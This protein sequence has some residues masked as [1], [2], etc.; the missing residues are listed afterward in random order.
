MAYRTPSV[1]SVFPL[2]ATTLALG[3]LALGT[4]AATALAQAPDASLLRSFDW[5]ARNASAKLLVENPATQASDLLEVLRAE[6]H[7]GIA[8]VNRWNSAVGLGGES[9]EPRQATLRSARDQIWRLYELSKPRQLTSA[10]QL[11]VPWHPHQLA[12]WILRQRYTKSDLPDLV[13]TSNELARIWLTCHRPDQDALRLALAD[14][15]TAPAVATAMWELDQGFPSSLLEYLASGSIAARRAVLRLPLPEAQLQPRHIRAVID[16]F[17][18][19]DDKQH[20]GHAGAVL[21]RLGE[22]AAVELIPH[23]SKGAEGQSKAAAVL[24]LMGSAAA[25]ATSALLECLHGDRNC[26]RRALVALSDIHMDPELRA[27]VAAKVFEVLTSTKTR[28]V[29]TVALDALA[30]CGDGVTAELK[31][32]LLAMFAKQPYRS[33]RTRMLGCMRRLQCLPK[34]TTAELVRIAGGSY[35]NTDTWMAVADRGQEAADA[36]AKCI[37]V[38]HPGVD[39][40]KVAAVLAQTAPQVLVQWLSSEERSLRLRA[41]QTLRAERLDLLDSN[42]LLSMLADQSVAGEAFD[43]LCSLP[44]ANALLPKILAATAPP[45]IYMGADRGP[46]LRKLG[47]DLPMLLKAFDAHLRRGDY[48][49]TVRGLDDDTLKKHARQWIE[50]SE[51]PKV[52]DQLRGEFVRL[53]LSQAVDLQMFAQALRSKHRAHTLAVM[54]WQKDLP[55]ELIPALEAICSDP[56]DREEFENA[57]KAL[58]IATR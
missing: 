55:R 6:W 46:V 8:E 34:L 48:W 20:A 24:C 9:R 28:L 12:E 27:T 41:L 14:E 25:P 2:S 21:V 54:S 16:Q 3:T 4:L 17:L 19:D 5:Q 36:I 29:R 43:A 30:N 10:H 40:A 47:A 23:L 52:R 50:Q 42:M 35:P 45:M 11:T 53:G 44:S 15:A 49:S 56:A 57:R 38:Y 22:P 18:H 58:S 13:P 33:V 7:D 51:D 39:D 37:R 32:R 1:R 26:Q 31:A